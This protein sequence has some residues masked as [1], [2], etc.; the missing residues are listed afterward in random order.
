MRPFP[1]KDEAVL[2]RASMDATEVVAGEDFGGGAELG[3]RGA[4]GVRAA[5]RDE[6]FGAVGVEELGGC[7]ADAVAAANDEGCFVCVG[8]CGYCAVWLVG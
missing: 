4:D 8:H 6:D 5:A 1:K 3:L 2:T 7:E